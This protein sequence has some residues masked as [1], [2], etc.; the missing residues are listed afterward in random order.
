MKL[1]KLYKVYYK[2]YRDVVGTLSVNVCAESEEQAANKVKN[3][4]LIF[5]AESGNSGLVK[6]VEYLGIEILE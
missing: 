6:K 1:L 4:D 2:P 3:S 5:I